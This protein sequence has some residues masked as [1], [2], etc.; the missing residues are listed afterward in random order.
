MPSVRLM[1]KHSV[2]TY[3]SIR[4]APYKKTVKTVTGNPAKWLPS[5][6]EHI[7]RLLPRP[8]Q[9]E[10]KAANIFGWDVYYESD[11][12]DSGLVRRVA[13]RRELGSGDI[14]FR[15]SPHPAV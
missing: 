13:R 4:C 15:L 12:D 8:Q 1:T 7:L 14:K 9:M 2:P 11:A 10:P 5:M 3:G 6:K